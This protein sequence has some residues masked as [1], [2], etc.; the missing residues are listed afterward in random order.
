[1]VSGMSLVEDRTGTIES[2]QLL[3]HAKQLAEDANAAKRQFLANVSHEM[4]TP[5]TAIVG[6]TELLDRQDVPPA[7]Q[8]DYLRAVQR[9]AQLLLSLVDHVLDF[10]QLEAG[11]LVVAPVDCSLWQILQDVLAATSMEAEQKRLR[12]EVACQYPL[13]DL[14]QTDPLRLWQILVNLVHNAVKFT[15]S[16]EVRIA[17]ALEAGE[18][19]AKR[20]RFTVSDTGTGIRPEWRDHLFEPFF[21][22]A[23]G[24]T[25]AQAGVG[26]G[27][28]F[29]ARLAELLSTRL[30][31]VPASAAGATFTFT[32]NPGPL[33]GRRLLWAPP[34][35]AGAATDLDEGRTGSGAEDRLE[36]RILLAE[37][38]AD[39]RELLRIHLELAGPAGRS[40]PG[41]AWLPSVRP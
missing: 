7:K 28:P 33:E 10:S 5:L 22:G 25:R 11:K 41:T 30:E 37:D 3:R 32:L 31:F 9:N 38:A 39:T 19:A 15:A 18:A 26:L 12:L 17:I 16:G 13:P 34:S 2:E 4:R 27:L 1:M 36:G 35:A 20:L 21:Q 23:T 24:A 8:R 6:F 40:C 29:A 14:I